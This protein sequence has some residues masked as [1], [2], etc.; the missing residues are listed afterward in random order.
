LSK[1]AA[2]SGPESNY[3]EA[4]NFLDVPAFS[5]LGEAQSAEKFP[6]TTADG[7]ILTTATSP[8]IEDPMAGRRLGAYRLVRRI[9]QGGMAAVF[10]AVR[11]D[12]EYQKEVAIKL[13]EPGPDSHELLSRFRNERQTLAGLDH[14]N[15]VKL[16]DGGSTP[17][18]LPFLVMDYV[19]GS[20]TDDYCDAHKLLVDERLRLFLKV[21]EAVQYAHQKSVVH[22]DLKPSNILVTTDGTPKLLDFGIA[23]VLNPQ[24]SAQRLQLTQT[25]AGPNFFGQ[26]DL[27]SMGGRLGVAVR[28]DPQHNI[29]VA[30]EQWVEQGIAPDAIIATKYVNDLDP[31]QGVRMTRPLCPYPQVAVYKGSGDTNDAANFACTKDR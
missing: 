27:S 25:G 10:L 6:D 30:L 1:T 14:P 23:K 19:D 2:T 29:F 7:A 16:L 4:G 3:L 15:I 28:M 20:P 22:R 18:G 11:A 9:G 21:C 17:E 12:D 8:E 24:P 5:G 31:S 13:L 26:V